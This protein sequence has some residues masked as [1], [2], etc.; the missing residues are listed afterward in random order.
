MQGAVLQAQGLGVLCLLAVQ[1]NSPL[2]YLFS[3]VL[4]KISGESCIVICLAF[5]NVIKH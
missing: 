1:G 2:Q 3:V 4:L 5:S